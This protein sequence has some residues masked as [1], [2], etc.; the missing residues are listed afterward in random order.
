MYGMLLESVAHF[1]QLEYG[2]D[3]W[4]EIRKAAK[5]DYQVFNTHQVYPDN[6]ISNLAVAAATVLGASYDSFMNFYG[7]CF[8]RFF[9][10]LGYDITVKATGRYFTDFLESVDNIHT[11]FRFTYPKMQSPS[12]YLTDID[13]NGCVLVYRSGRQGFTQYIMGQLVQV[14]K[15]FYNLTLN[16]KV[17]EKASS[18]SGS[19]NYVIVTF[20]LNFDNRAYMLHKSRKE[21][22]HRS[23]LLKSFSSEILLELFP[24]CLIIDDQMHIV[25]TGKKFLEI[26]KGTEYF[27]D[28]PLTNYFK[29]RRPKGISFTWKNT[30]NLQS[31]MFEMECNRGVQNYNDVP[32][33]GVAANE[34]PDPSTP[35]EIKNIILKGQMKY[36]KDINAIIYLC[37]PVIND[38]DDLT[39]QALYLNDLN[40]HG[41]SKELVLAGWQHNSKLEVMF[42]KAEQRSDELDKNYKLLE[43]WKQRGDELLYS[44]MPKTVADRLRSTESSL[45]TCEAFDSVSILFCELVGLTSKTVRE[46]MVVVSTMNTV[47]SSFDSL[48]DKFNVYKVE[49]VGQVYMVAS[50][51]PEKTPLHGQKIADLA[52]A[53]IQEIKKIRNTDS[54]EVDVKIGIHSGPAV[55]GVVGIKVPRY[56]FF[57]DTINT[58]SRM[59]STSEPGKI[60]LSRYTQDLISKHKY[61]TESRGLVKVKG[62]GN[63][64]TYWLLGR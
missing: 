27:Y 46:T 18:A 51:A 1:I 13:V 60:H 10:H 29:L 63:M 7:R 33:E 19:R 49:T 50:G 43:S 22:F 56:C 40:P 36:I 31:V 58:A 53:M 23:G 14:A 30:L 37:S 34:E 41:L 24:F 8:V 6:L 61:K 42:D 45:S 26:W 3:V 47:F 55:A 35:K 21:S 38:L 15:D 4:T 11:Q 52:L 9:T 20:R 5:C 32:E 28:K 57:G 25:S 12:M 62:K 54:S 44:M 48:M 64:Q 16:V 39:D 2:E 59:Q 17:L